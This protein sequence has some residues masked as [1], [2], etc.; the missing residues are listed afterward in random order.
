MND[1]MSRCW[2]YSR[3]MTMP[4]ARASAI[5]SST[6]PA[7]ALR[8]GVELPER[9]PVG[10]QVGVGQDRVL[11][12]LLEV[13][14]G[15]QLV[16]LHL[17]ELGGV[18]CLRS[19]A[20]DH[21]GDHLAGERRPV[22]G[23]R[24][25]VRRLLV[26]C[27]RPRRDQRALLL[28]DLRAGDDGHDVRRVLGRGGVDARDPGVR[29]RAAHHRDVQHPGQLDVVGPARPAGDQP[30]VLLA[31]PRGADLRTGLGRRGLG[32]GHD[33]LPSN[34]GTSSTSWPAA[35]CTARTMLW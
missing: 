24:R 31:A 28:G 25:V 18:A 21:H 5:A 7:A 13:E 26:R 11:G 1:G 14:H 23:D 6:S 30:L 27:D 15:P 8:R 12:R 10:P 29:E 9:R 16:V 35:S 20:G 34:V 2:R 3:S 4:L 17:D 32:G 33:A 19:G 22:D